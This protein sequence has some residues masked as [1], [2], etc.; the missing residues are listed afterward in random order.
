MA[1]SGTES[2]LQPPA[3]M[4][5]QLWQVA[6]SAGI[7]SPAKAAE[8]LS[9]RLPPAFDSD[10]RMPPDGEGTQLSTEEVGLLRGVD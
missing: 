7:F 10:E 1:T 5:R 9:V 3:A 6:I 4:G 2:G 8:S